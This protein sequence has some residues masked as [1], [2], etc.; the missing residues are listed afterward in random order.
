MA[1]ERVHSILGEKRR[2]A[3][4]CLP[5][6]LAHLVAAAAPPL[7][8]VLRPAATA[9]L[10]ASSTA[11]AQAAGS[12]CRRTSRRCCT[13]TLHCMKPTLSLSTQSTSVVVSMRWWRWWRRRR[14]LR[15]RS[16]RTRSG[17]SPV[18]QTQRLQVAAATAKAMLRLGRRVRRWSSGQTSSKSSPSSRQRRKTRM[19]QIKTNRRAPGHLQRAVSYHFL[20]ATLVLLEMFKMQF[21]GPTIGSEEIFLA[22]LLIVGIRSRC[23]STAM[24]AA[25]AAA[26]ASA[27]A[28]ATIAVAAIAAAAAPPG[29]AILTRPHL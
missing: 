17:L 24:V 18:P 27:A 28:A 8:T 12:D 16:V 10:P 7:T 19:D 23:R 20:P 5:T 4:A 26:A 2:S 22:S 6:L 14:A 1:A 21:I 25:A 29:E 13:L 11:S 9:A 3:G 15:R